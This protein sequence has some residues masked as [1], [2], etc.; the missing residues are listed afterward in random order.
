MCLFYSKESKQP[1]L[2]Y[3]DIGYLSDPLKARSQTGYVFNCNE[4]TISWR[5]FKQIMVAISL[6]KDFS[7]SR[8]KS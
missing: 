7:N 6:F 5:S 4:N 2:G 1:L 3:A 8:S